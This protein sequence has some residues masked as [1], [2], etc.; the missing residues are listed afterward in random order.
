MPAK[1]KRNQ[2]KERG[3]LNPAS[4]VLDEAN[5]NFDPVA[6]D[7]LIACCYWEYA[8]ESE[9]IL[10]VK[11]RCLDPQ[12][13]QL[14]NA[15]L[16]SF[17][18]ADIE[19][20]QTLGQP[21]D[22]FL[23]GFFFDWDA[24][25]KPKHPQ[26][27]PIT[28]SF[29]IPWQMLSPKERRQRSRIS[30]DRE[31]IP[32]RPFDRAYPFFAGWIAEHVESRRKVTGKPVHPSLCTPSGEVGVFTINWAA[33]TNEE[34]CD[35]FQRWLTPNR[36]TQQPAPDGRG[37]KTRDWR[38][39]L[40]RLAMM[41]LLHHFRLRDLPVKASAAGRLYQKREWYKERKR[42]GEMFHQLFAFL[43]VTDQPVSWR[44]KGGRS[45]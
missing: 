29:P 19:R 33:F 5:W 13:Q 40:E 6:D 20:I 28:G 9:F 15:E 17:V 12:C 31:S 16:T 42:A 3:A 45:R 27:P 21:A 35:G 7:E 44:T 18:G 11:R 41:R 37:R 39:A 36:P 32:L 4:A 26:A 2:R 43:P 22:V 24:P 34:L 25:K 10:D 23:R 38:V 14:P 1:A 30:T 8:R